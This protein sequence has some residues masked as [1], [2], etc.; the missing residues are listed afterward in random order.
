MG[1]PHMPPLREVTA[2]GN[3]MPKKQVD[4]VTFEEIRSLHKKIGWLKQNARDADEFKK[5][6]ESLETLFELCRDLEEGPKPLQGY[7]E[8]LE[9][10]E[11]AEAEAKAVEQRPIEPLPTLQYVLLKLKSHWKFVCNGEEEIKK[12][13]LLQIEWVVFRLI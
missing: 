8:L 10:L 11:E 13:D 3:I 12:H 5:R 7:P 1:L 2:G 4:Q 6:R 9:R